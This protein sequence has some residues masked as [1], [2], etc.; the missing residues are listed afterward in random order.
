MWA[1]IDRGCV[2]LSDIVVDQSEKQLA[3]SSIKKAQ[4]HSCVVWGHGFFSTHLQLLSVGLHMK[5]Q[6]SSYRN[7]MKSIGLSVCHKFWSRSTECIGGLTYFSRG[8]RMI[9][10]GLLWPD[11]SATWWYSFQ[12]HIR[13]YQWTVTLSWSWPEQKC[14]VTC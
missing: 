7:G 4:L 11:S 9:Q 12:R 5:Q 1:T 6:S 2:G 14:L 10:G 8:R 3:G 13:L